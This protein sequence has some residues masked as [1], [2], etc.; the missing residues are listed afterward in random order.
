VLLQRETKQTNAKS[1]RLGSSPGSAAS[2]YHESSH[3]FD[4]KTISNCGLAASYGHCCAIGC[5]AD[6]STY[7]SGPHNIEHLGIFLFTGLVFG[8]GYETR[9]LAQAFGLVIFSAA[10]ELIQL[11]IPGRHARF[12]DFVVDALSV[13]IGTVLAWAISA[14]W[15]RG[16]RRP[17]D[18]TDS[19]RG[20]QA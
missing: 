6:R 1:E 12:S 8:L 19:S 15:N 5:S 13:S 4:E 16:P 11:A 9:H 17:R 14:C 10:I 18:V 2:M 20:Y 3:S 7:N